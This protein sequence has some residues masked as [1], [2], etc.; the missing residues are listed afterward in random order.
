MLRA[1]RKTALGFC[2]ALGLLLLVATLLVGMSVTESP[3]PMVNVAIMVVSGCTG[4]LLCL[5]AAYLDKKYP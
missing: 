5:N 1:I 2:M 3:D 4:T